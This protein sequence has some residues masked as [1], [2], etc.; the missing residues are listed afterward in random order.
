MRIGL[1]APPWIAVP[2]PSYG[3]TESVIDNLARGLVDRG[4]EVVLFTVGTS[5]V[6]V[7]RDFLY[8]EPVEPMGL[9]V[10]EAAHTLAAHDAL[11]DVDVIHDHT[12]LGP[13]LSRP[14]VDAGR[15]RAAPPVVTTVHGRFTSDTRRLY[16]A[17]ARQTAVV[18]ISADQARRAGGDV[19]VSAVIHHGIDTDTY[20]PGPGGGDHLVFVGRMSP[21]K[22]VDRAVRIARAAGRPLRIFSKVPDQDEADYYETRVRPLLGADEQPLFGAGLEERIAVLGTAAGLLNP[23]A[24]PEP[25][26]L[27]MAE[28]LAVGTP[29]ITWSLGAAPEIITHGRTGFLCDS[30]ESAVAAVARLA[31]ID[32]AGCRA[33]AERRFSRV[34]MAADHERLYASLVGPAAGRTCPTKPLGGHAAA[35]LVV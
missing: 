4:H 30:E 24:W 21:E 31:E 15:G 29:V 6:P 12:V 32:R 19:P 3:G 20:R 27:V 25:F 5:T 17:I 26:G 14:P 18:T 1:V 8:A 13:L 16:R 28:S 7:Q 33:E 23:I 34:R 35:R 2:P 22:G 11:R 9:S 10:P